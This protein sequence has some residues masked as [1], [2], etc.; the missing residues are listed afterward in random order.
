MMLRVRQSTSTSTDD[1]LGL[2]LVSGTLRGVLASSFACEMYGS[3]RHR[4]VEVMAVE[5]D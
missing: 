2:D 1:V 5:L 3:I 4:A